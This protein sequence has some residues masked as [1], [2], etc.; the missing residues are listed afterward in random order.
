MYR[1]ASTFHNTTISSISGCAQRHELDDE[2]AI[3][4]DI[5]DRR[6]A[7]IS[8]RH[9]A[10][11]RLVRRYELAC[12]ADRVNRKAIRASSIQEIEAP[13]SPP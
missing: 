13:R 9:I 7:P 4:V 3:R 1:V 12:V 2:L 11:S 10:R 5:E 8:R 6:R